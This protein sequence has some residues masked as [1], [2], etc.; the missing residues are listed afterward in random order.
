MTDYCTLD[1]A[2]VELKSSSN[3]TDDAK[4]RQF[5]KQVSARIDR[6]MGSKRRPYFAPYTEQRQYHIDNKR[7]DSLNNVFWLWDYI[8]SFSAVERAGEDITSSVELYDPDNDVK[9]ALRITNW[10]TDWYTYSTSSSDMPP[11]FVK[12]TG[13]WGWNTDYTNAYDTVDAV[14]GVGGINATTTSITVSDVDGVDLDGFIPRLSPGNLI[15]I[16]SELMDVTATNT[17]TN[18]MTVRRGVN[19]TT[20]VIHAQGASIEVYRVDETIQRITAR[21]A[22]LLY[23]R[24]GAFQIETIDDV[25]TISYPQDLLTELKATLTEFV[26]G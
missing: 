23:A 10:G 25:G 9:S 12:V 3:S 18:I 16:G 26:Y 17:T 13:V 24:R 22:A 5:I 21:Q 4:L 19:G 15:R 20:A 2:R 11:A 7:I 14:Q 8:L 6:Q 1:Y